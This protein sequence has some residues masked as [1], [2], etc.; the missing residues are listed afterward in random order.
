[1]TGLEKIAEAI[2]AECSE[3]C[4]GI[5]A[6]AQAECRTISVGFDQEAARMKADH[7]AR[8]ESE[9]AAVI[10]SAASEARMAAASR[11]LRTKGELIDRAID[12]ACD[13]IRSLPAAEYFDELTALLAKTSGKGI[14]YLSKT[15][16]ERLPASFESRL[17]ERYPGVTLDNTDLTRVADGFLLVDGNIEYDCS[18]AALASEKSD[19]LRLAA[20]RLLF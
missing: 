8:L 11:L 14:M 1:M 12:A 6:E 18:I 17:A 16:A 13:K 9:R 19:E 3:Q 5:M 7:R 4:G 20:A 15:D 10:E 2:R